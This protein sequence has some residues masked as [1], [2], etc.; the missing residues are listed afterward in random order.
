MPVWRADI[1]CSW[2]MAPAS[3]M[4]GVSRDMPVELRRTSRVNSRP[5]MRPASQSTKT[6]SGL[7]VRPSVNASMAVAAA[8]MLV[9][10]RRRSES[11]MTPRM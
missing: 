9:I 3:R 11:A 5:D 6:I 4:I 10:I 8:L 1:S 2:S 7:N